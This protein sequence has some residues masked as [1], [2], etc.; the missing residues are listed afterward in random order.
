[1]SDT[2][3]CTV[4]AVRTAH[5]ARTTKE[6]DIAVTLDLDGTGVTHV[7]TGIGFLDH[8]LEAFGRH[9]SFDLDVSC[10][11]DLMVDGHHTTEDIGIAVGQVLAHALGDRAGIARYGDINLPMDEALMLV[12]V[13]ISGRGRLYWDCDIPLQYLGDFDTALT[14]EFFDALAANSGVTLHIRQL[15]GE[16]AHHEI[17]AVFKGTARALRAAVAFDPR[18]TGVVPSTKGVL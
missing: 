15:A 10:T 13:D 17:E 8:M 12:A 11:G 4:P 6:T 1:M 18:C 9:A 14:R 7:S 2:K 16:N 3:G 5:I